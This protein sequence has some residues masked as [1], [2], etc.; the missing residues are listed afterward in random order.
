[1]PLSWVSSAAS[2]QC[3]TF[4]SCVGLLIALRGGLLIALGDGGRGKGDRGKHR[5]ESAFHDSPSSAD[6][7]EL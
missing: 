6:L 5:K 7:L 4:S 3:W 2:A 1:M